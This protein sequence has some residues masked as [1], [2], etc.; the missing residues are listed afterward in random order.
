M[1]FGSSGIRR[2]FDEDLLKLSVSVGIAVAKNNK[3]VVVGRDARTTGNLLMQGFMAGAMYAGADVINGGIAPTPTVA[4]AAK[5]SDAGCCI[6]ASH[7]P[8][9]YNGI[10]LINPDGSAFTK[11]QQKEIGDLLNDPDT[12]DWQ[13]QGDV[14]VK[15]IISGHKKAILEKI[16][17]KSGTDMVVDCGGGA[18]CMITPGLLKEAGVKTNCINCHISGKFPRPS[19][20]LEKNL[21]YIPAMIK[22]TKSAGAIIHDGDADRFMAFDEK[23]R[24]IGGDHM[25]MLFSEYLGAKRVVTTADASMAIEEIADVHRTPVGDSYVSEELLSWGDFGGEPSGS[26]LFPGHSLCPDGIYAA[27]LFARI[28][29]ETNISEITDKM[30]DYPILRSSYVCENA[31]DIL[32]KLGADIPTDG[33]RISDEDGWCLIRASGTEP[34]VRITAEGRTKQKAKE[35]EEKGK[36]ILSSGK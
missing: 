23:G 33:I 8:E 6:T 28:A 12:S 21:H 35:M 16:S 22:K 3:S 17:I 30:P 29:A 26:W 20:P 2:I 10:K 25:L 24:Y 4:Y 9:E 15:D 13:L 31:K 36:K 7:N 5:T 18:G 11:N 34:K 14:S 27:A 19:E 32:I 1:L